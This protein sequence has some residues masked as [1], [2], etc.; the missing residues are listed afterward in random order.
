MKFLS[1]FKKLLFQPLLGPLIERQAA[2]LA[3]ALASA[4]LFVGIWLR[5]PLF[6]CPFPKLFGIPCPGCG[7]T[8]AS[9]FLLRGE[10]KHA[11][12]FHAFAPIALFAVVAFWI[13]AILPSPSRKKFG[14][15][16]TRIEMRYGISNFIC[17][18]ILV[19]WLMRLFSG[20]SI[21]LLI[22]TG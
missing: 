16:I 1:L 20:V 10:F 2:C 7:M 9:F 22:G 6:E 21:P 14:Q 17:C 8:R 19:Y 18:G 4:T 12:E 13:A 11:F 5:I 15:F 3:F